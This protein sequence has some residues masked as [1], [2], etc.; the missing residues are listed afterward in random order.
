M[1]DR[2]FTRIAAALAVLG[3]WTQVAAASPVGDIGA[4]CVAQAAHD[5]LGRRACAAEAAIEITRGPDI[6]SRRPAGTLAAFLTAVTT[7][8]LAHQNICARTDAFVPVSYF[9]PRAW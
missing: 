1:L 2:N 6:C 5:D 8:R 7:I 9:Q 4:R 3:G